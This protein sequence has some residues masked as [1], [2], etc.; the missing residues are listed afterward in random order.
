MPSTTCSSARLPA[1][2]RLRRRG[3]RAA[4]PARRRQRNGAAVDHVDQRAVAQGAQVR[5][6]KRLVVGEIG[7]ARFQVPAE[8]HQAAFDLR[9]QF[10]TRVLKL[11]GLHFD[12]T[13]ATKP[14]EIVVAVGA[15]GASDQMA[16]MMQAAIQKNNLMKQPVV[17]SLKTLPASSYVHELVPYVVSLTP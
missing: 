16:R 10:L 3:R 2:N 5:G 12:F 8:L 15:G 13:D 4:P 14:V 6:G 9:S 17:V 7:D 1:G 11:G